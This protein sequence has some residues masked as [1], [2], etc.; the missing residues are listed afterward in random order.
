MISF[1]ELDHIQG[2]LYNNMNIINLL[3]WLWEICGAKACP[4]VT[5]V[6]SIEI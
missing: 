5:A 4:L 3:S 6:L 1:H 2:Y